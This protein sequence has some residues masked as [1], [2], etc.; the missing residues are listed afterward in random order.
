MPAMQRFIQQGVDVKQKDD[1]GFSVLHY[2]NGC[3]PGEGVWQR[4][5]T[6]W[7]IVFTKSSQ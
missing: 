5:A 3:R 2:A 6:K 1:A 7:A 4:F